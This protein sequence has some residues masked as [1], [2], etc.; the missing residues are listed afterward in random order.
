MSQVVR[1]RGSLSWN[2]WVQFAQLNDSLASLFVLTCKPERN[3]TP[4][5]PLGYSG[6]FGNA[7]QQSF[8]EAGIKLNTAHVTEWEWTP[9]QH[10][11]LLGTAARCRLQA[12]TCITVWQ[13][14]EKSF[15]CV[16]AHTVHP[17]GTRPHWSNTTSVPLNII[18]RLEN[19][20]LKSR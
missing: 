19:A 3:A 16:R 1:E 7:S 18:H 14:P 9:L 4:S 13:F 6:R 10:D 2:V 20:G 15:P 8:T 5:S 17:R 12:D 11:S